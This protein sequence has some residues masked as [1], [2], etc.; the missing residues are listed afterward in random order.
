MWEDVS[1]ELELLRKLHTFEPY[2]TSA[3]GRVLPQDD[4]I[5]RKYD[6]FVCS[7]RT[8]I[9]KYDIYFNSF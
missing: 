6:T 2:V 7:Y 3:V 9:T 8:N 1:A 5:R 4:Y